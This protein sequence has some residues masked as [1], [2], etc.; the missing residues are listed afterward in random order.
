[1]TYTPKLFA[2]NN[3]CL[4][5]SANITNTALGWRTPANLELLV[6]VP[7]TDSNVV[8][9]EKELLTGAV[10]ATAEHR[11][12]L[13]NLMNKLDQNSAVMQVAINDLAVNG[14]LPPSWLPRTKNPDELYLYYSGN[15]DFGRTVAQTMSEEIEQ[16]GLPSGM[17]EENF[18][19]WVAAAI[20]QTP[21]VCKV[22][23][24][25]DEHGEVTEA[26]LFDLLTNIGVNTQVH[27]FR[28][29]LQVLERWLTYFLPDHYETTSDKIKLIKAKSV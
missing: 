1:M 12:Y 11:T 8:A 20:T 19:M 29:V 7:R 22:K 9:F 25:L 10:R 13:Q 24:Y 3:S 14:V 23:Q 4:V 17:S 26:V 21:L 16:I 6:D 5:G 15:H 2:T 18:R 27:S 28:E